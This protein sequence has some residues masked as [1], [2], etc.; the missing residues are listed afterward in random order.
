MKWVKLE[1]PEWADLEERLFELAQPQVVLALELEQVGALL[2][3]VGPL[4]L[5]HRVEALRLQRAARHRE[6]DEGDAR[7]NVGRELDARVARRQEDGEGRRQVNVLI[8]EGDEDAA[9]GAAQ[10]AV[11]HR[12]EDGVVVFDVLH[13]QRVAEAQRR[14]EVLAEGVVEEAGPRDLAVLRVE[15]RRNGGLS[16]FTKA[17]GGRDGH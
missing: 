11:E 3:D 1:G 12:V 15:Q 9:A 6:V 14:L 5:E 7:A 2:V 8:A 16:V 17:V 10:L 13:Q 4:G